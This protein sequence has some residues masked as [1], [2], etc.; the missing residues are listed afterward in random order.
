MKRVW[1][2]VGNGSI[3]LFFITVLLCVS[4]ESFGTDGAGSGDIHGVL[5]LRSLKSK[6]FGSFS[7]GDARIEI[8]SEE[9][10]D[11]LFQVEVEFDQLVLK[12]LIDRENELAILDGFDKKTGLDSYIARE[13]RAI[14]KKL[15]IELSQALEKADPSVEQLEHVVSI[16]A[17]YPLTL[18]LTLPVFAHKVLS[19]ESLCHAMGQAVRATHDDGD[20]DRGDDES[21]LEKAYVSPPEWGSCAAADNTWF[22]VGGR[23]DCVEP[24]HDPAIEEAKGNCF[25][26]CGA[27][28]SGTGRQM[29]QDCHDHDQCVRNGHAIASA[30]CNDEFVSAADDELNAPDCDAPGGTHSPGVEAAGEKAENGIGKDWKLG[31]LRMM[32]EILEGQGSASHKA[33]TSGSEKALGDLHAEGIAYLRTRIVIGKIGRLVENMESGEIDYFME[34]DSQKKRDKVLERIE[35]IGDEV[36][37]LHQKMEELNKRKDRVE[38]IIKEL[39]LIREEAAH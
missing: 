19:I 9:V 18:D 4:A 10:I 7:E 22:K 30:W 12:A 31:R 39:N 33:L 17:E 20:F 32:I 23:W 35:G 34:S 38:S 5:E 6:S 26:N 14:L 27:G 8:R 29:T 24:D 16:W 11:G 13:D 1:K 3:I 15:D 36:N 21:T 37:V 2:R 28:C 25:G